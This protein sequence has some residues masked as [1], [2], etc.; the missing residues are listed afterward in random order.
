MNKGTYSRYMLAGKS[1]M[2]FALFAFA[3]SVLAWLFLDAFCFDVISLLLL[4]V[5]RAVQKGSR[6]AAIAAV[7]LLLLYV[8]LY[9][10]MS[11]ADGRL[12]GLSRAVLTQPVLLAEVLLVVVISAWAFVN[13]VLCVRAVS[14]RHYRSQT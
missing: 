7:P 14:G 9:V 11:M 3:W 13:V 1:T 12:S 4:F 2:Y 6:V 10:S 8:V 5:A